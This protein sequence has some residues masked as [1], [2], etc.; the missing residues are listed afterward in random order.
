MSTSTSFICRQYIARI[1]QSNSARIIS[2]RFE[3]HTQAI[4]TAAPQ[5]IWTYPA[6]QRQEPSTEFDVAD[7]YEAGFPTYDPALP[8][9]ASRDE[10]VAE[11]QLNWD[12]NLKKFVL[13]RQRSD[14]KKLRNL[15]VNGSHDLKKKILRCLGDYSVVYEDLMHIYGLSAGEARHAMRQLERLLGGRSA[16]EAGE[17]LDHFHI[18]KS[19]FKELSEIVASLH[20]ITGLDDDSSKRP[21]WTPSTR[22]DS[23]AMK[24][25][26]QRQDRTRRK[27]LW[28]QTMI[29][30]FRSHPSTIPSLMRATFQPSWCP[31]YIVE[32]IVY[33]LSQTLNDTQPN[34]SDHRQVTELVFFLLR[35]ST[36][37]YLVLEQQVIWKIMSS[38][39]TSKLVELHEDLKRIEH[40]LN[41][42]TLLHFASRFTRGSKYKVLAA[43]IIHSLS[44]IPEFNINSPAATS[45]CTS[46]LSVQEGQLPGDHAAPDELFKMLLDTG[47][48]PNI[49]TLTTLMRN[50][51]VR[52]R[53]EVALDIFDL[54]ADRDIEPDPH[55]FSIL[56]NG[57]KIALDVESLR[58][59]YIMI[60]A[61]K[62][63]STHLVND[64]LDFIYQ[65][66]EAQRGHRR[67]Q[68]KRDTARAWRLM[69][70]VYI[71]FFKLAPL[72][73]LTL[74]PLENLLATRPE[75][76]SPKLKEVYQLTSTLKSL[77]DALLMQPDSTTLA[78]MFRVHFW[79]IQRPAPLQMYYKYFIRCLNKGDPII[80]RIVQDQGTMVFD[81]F[82]RDFMQFKPTFA[83]GVGIVQSM[84]DRANKENKELGKN[85]LCPPPSAHTY[86]ILM[87]GLRNHKRI[88]GVIMALNMMIKEGITPNIVTWNTV[89]GALLQ[90]GYLEEAVRVMRNLK[91]V[92]LE[93]NARTVKEITSVSRIK[94][95]AI[96]TLMKKMGEE[97]ADITDQRLFAESL[98]RRWEKQDEKLIS[99]RFTRRRN[100]RFDRRRELT[101][102]STAWSDV[103]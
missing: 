1:A 69:F 17:L 65:Y 48:Q 52:G 13:R 75:Q 30:A 70:H 53:V 9:H 71:K 73:K 20:S 41:Q 102:P 32:D 43:E 42:H 2:R 96:A 16:A 78:L 47:F 60:E 56:M 95:K 44:S 84:H 10:A 35:N 67:R 22:Q 76:I 46:L 51:C 7:N 12:G 103:A 34:K 87:T 39:P 89:I 11:H 29:S 86:T 72:Q 19:H 50:F 49:I 93:S 59:I 97:P 81:T 14:V 36:P 83:S 18:W 21:L 40:P 64:V 38:I 57:A 92:G 66:N 68:R 23:E 33:L 63:W 3:L 82:L 91:H 15:Q 26:W 85:I 27:V 5:P 8:P 31:S 100:G 77:P 62:L 90:A 25:V 54:L 55:I 99:H 88:Q 24:D 58:R 79:T 94:R 98:L 6:E 28:P 74:F 61:R 101:Q 80:T 4:S 37:R 45:V